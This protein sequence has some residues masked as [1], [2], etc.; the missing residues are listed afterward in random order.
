[1]SLL[2]HKTSIHSVDILVLQVASKLNYAH[3]GMYLVWRGAVS[4]GF[5]IYRLSHASSISFDI[6]AEDFFY[7]PNRFLN[8]LFVKNSH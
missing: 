7:K 3:I 2:V 5:L 6:L 1:M 8:E 4:S